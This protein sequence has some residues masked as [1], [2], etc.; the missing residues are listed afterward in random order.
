MQQS[1]IEIAHTVDSK[2]DGLNAKCEKLEMKLEKAQKKTE[3]IAK[4]TAQENRRMDEAAVDVFAQCIEAVKAEVRQRKEE[5]VRKLN[6]I[7]TKSLNAER[8]GSPERK[9]QDSSQRRY[10]GQSPSSYIYF[11]DSSGL[12]GKGPKE[13]EASP[14]LL[15]LDKF[16]ILELFV[17]HEAIEHA[18]KSL[19][20]QEHLS[21]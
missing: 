10:T 21:P 11:N 7:E 20:G 19:L 13:R 18:L 12:A 2:F 5:Q 3:T 8:Q 6:S 14:K 4:A 15:T 16:K 1:L 9:G 17:K